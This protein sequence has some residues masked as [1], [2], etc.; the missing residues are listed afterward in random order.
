MPHMCAGP[1][2]PWRPGRSDKDENA[3]PL[4]DGRLPDASLDNKHL[5]DIF[6]RWAH[7]QHAWECWWE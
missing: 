6:Y 3:I 7:G 1:H 2:I 5:R 4:P